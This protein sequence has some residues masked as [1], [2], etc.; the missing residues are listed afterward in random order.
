VVGLRC[1][2]AR[3]RLLGMLLRGLVSG[4]VLVKIF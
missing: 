1:L 3:V 4:Q 2:G